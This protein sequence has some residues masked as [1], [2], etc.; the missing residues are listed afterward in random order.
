MLQNVQHEKKK[1]KRVAT[2]REAVKCGLSLPWQCMADQWLMGKGKRDRLPLLAFPDWPVLLGSG[3]AN[4]IRSA[5]AARE[6]NQSVSPC[7]HIT[8]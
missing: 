1:K 7:P 5:S 4:D 3:E 6:A 2:N 8:L